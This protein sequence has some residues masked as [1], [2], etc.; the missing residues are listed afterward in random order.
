MADKI[1][2]LEGDLD[3]RAYY[4]SRR[5]GRPTLWQL[6]AFFLLHVPLAIAMRSYPTI[7]TVHSLLVLAVGLWL[8]FKSRSLSL[9]AF[10]VAY[11]AGS[12]VLWRMT[13]AS[14]VW[15][16]GKYAT[17]AIL[18]VALLRIRRLR[19]SSL[20]LLYFLVLVPGTVI[21][22]T[23]V[24][25]SEAKDMLSFDLS[26]PLQLTVCALFFAQVRLSRESYLKVVGSFVAPVMGIAGIILLELGT[27]AVT[28]GSS[29]NV[30]A[31]G[32]FGPNQVSAALGLACA[33][34]FMAVV[35]EKLP[36]ATKLSFLGCIFLF[37][38]LSA[39][40]FSRAGIYYSVASIVAA[41]V[42]LL[43]TFRHSVQVLGAL[44]VVFLISYYFLLPWMGQ[45]TGGALVT[46]FE[47][48]ELTGRQE[49]M[50]A[51]LK[52]FAENPV[53][54]VGVGQAVQARSRYYLMNASHTEFTRLLSEHGLF[55]IIAII[56]LMSMALRN[57]FLAK[58]SLGKALVACLVTFSFMFM[59]GNGM[60]LAL[61][62]FCFGL[63]SVQLAFESRV[64]RV[65]RLRLYSRKPE[66][67]R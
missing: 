51:D 25:F 7:G 20:P 28:F 63:S 59:T 65:F 60:R 40:T 17:I 53:F 67:E 30:A 43:R 4:G 44:L 66:R 57:L 45:F 21:T 48:K 55:G 3:S 11:I 54:G 34:S 23:E 50:E 31:S 13:R 42:F 38:G 37:G 36:M 61:A 58:S 52:V 64:P 15:E 9:V 49:L 24:Q 26:G 14:V 62:G 12:E 27:T 2:R 41:S 16:F 22:L 1:L 5:A 10:V 33:F 8:A 39:L 46:R 35:S 47:N 32:G 18:F 19:M 29:S 56:S 6:G